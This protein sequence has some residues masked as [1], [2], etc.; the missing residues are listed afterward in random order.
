MLSQADY[1]ALMG[2]RDILA[3]DTPVETEQV[4]EAG[5]Y[6]IM[7]LGYYGKPITEA[8]I[9]ALHEG[10]HWDP[11]EF[12]LQVDACDGSSLKEFDSLEAL[13]AEAH[14]WRGSI[15]TGPRTAQDEGTRL[16]L[17]GATWEDL[18]MCKSDCYLAVARDPTDMEDP[19]T[20][21]KEKE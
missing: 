13:R 21:P 6:E 12:G 4:S 8:T 11:P 3:F 18:G 15:Y 5:A 7:N 20:P 17:I 2:M 14:G 10:K 9:K 16:E 1:D 19:A